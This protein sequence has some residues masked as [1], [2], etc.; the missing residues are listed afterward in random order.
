MPF[1][2]TDAARFEVRESGIVRPGDVTSKRI[3]HPRYMVIIETIRSIEL[4][5]I[6]ALMAVISTAGC[7]AKVTAPGVELESGPVKVEVG[8]SDGSGHN[9]KFCPPGQA[10]KGRC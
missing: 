3:T 1:L 9:G 10:K 7:M 8:D 5:F 6:I 4:K 2:N